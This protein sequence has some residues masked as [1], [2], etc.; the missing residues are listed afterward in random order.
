MVLVTSMVG[1]TYMV[2]AH[3][4]LICTHIQLFTYVP[5]KVNENGM[6]EELVV[7]ETAENLM[8]N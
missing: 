3:T 5:G 8:N 1:M 7:G 2:S 4:L 6:Y